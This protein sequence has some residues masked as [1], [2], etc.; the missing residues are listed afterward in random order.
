M[1]CMTDYIYTHSYLLLLHSKHKKLNLS[2]MDF[3][4]H[5]ANYQRNPSDQPYLLEAMES[6]QFKQSTTSKLH[7]YSKPKPIRTYH[8]RP[9]YTTSTNAIPFYQSPIFKKPIRPLKRASNYQNY[10]DLIKIRPPPPR[11]AN[12]SHSKKLL[13]MNQNVQPGTIVEAKGEIEKLVL[14]AE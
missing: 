7:Q 5:P 12:L 4:P 11:L 13:L 10:P 2:P 1:C 14:A 6:T 8:R 3:T 9:K